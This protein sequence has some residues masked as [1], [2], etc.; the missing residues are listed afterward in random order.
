[1][2]KEIIILLGLLFFISGCFTSNNFDP[3]QVDTID[4]IEEGKIDSLIRLMKDQ[5]KIVVLDK[6]EVSLEGS[7]KS[8][9]L[10]IHNI[11]PLPHIYTISMDNCES[12]QQEECQ[13]ELVF[14][15]TTE[16]PGESFEFIDIEVKKTGEYQDVNRVDLLIKDEQNRENYVNL[17]VTVG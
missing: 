3:K 17:F 9:L 7:D 2:R 16:I 10:G 14:I 13:H 11:D 12:I 15:E 8:V 6:H 4:P 1:M 5:N